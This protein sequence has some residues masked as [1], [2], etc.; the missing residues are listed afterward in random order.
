VCQIGTCSTT[1][2][3]FD[4]VTCP[5][6]TSKCHEPICVPFN[7]CDFVDIDCSKVLD[8]SLKSACGV[9]SCNITTG[10]EFTRQ[11]CYAAIVA[12]TT[13]IAIGSTLGTAAIIGIVAALVALFVLTGG[14]SYG[15]Y[16]SSQ[17]S[18]DSSVANN[19]IYQAS[20]N[21]G[22]NPLYE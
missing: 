18:P 21:A 11:E 3:V 1:G 7:G 2:C 15:Y 22:D 4:E 19:P 13:A 5:A 9:Y 20:G 14:A 16:H 17:N 8:S 6:D 12:D 10:C